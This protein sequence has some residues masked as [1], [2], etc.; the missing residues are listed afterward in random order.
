MAETQPE[1]VA[2]PTNFKRVCRICRR[3]WV[4]IYAEERDVCPICSLKG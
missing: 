3:V 1:I 2:K 4:V